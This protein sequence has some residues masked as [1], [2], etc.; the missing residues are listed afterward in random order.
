MA[1]DTSLVDAEILNMYLAPGFDPAML[2]DGFPVHVMHDML[3]LPL[4]C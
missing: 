4:L 1:P 3:L 2:F